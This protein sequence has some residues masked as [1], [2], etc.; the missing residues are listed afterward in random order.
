MGSWAADEAK[1]SQVATC[2]QK[3]RETVPLKEV[4]GAK[5]EDKHDDSY[6]NSP[7]HRRGE[8]GSYVT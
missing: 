7:T 8:V 2:S 3:V 4:A 5:E 1:T 6:A